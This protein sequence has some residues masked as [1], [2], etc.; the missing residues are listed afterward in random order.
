MK[1][2]LNKDNYIKH[3]DNIYLGPQITKLEIEKF[4]KQKKLKNKYL[5][6]KN[7]TAKIHSSRDF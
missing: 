7:I 2:N 4:I 1:K 5:I 6:K 3:I